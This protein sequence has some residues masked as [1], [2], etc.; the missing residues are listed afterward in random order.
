MLDKN[1]E[2]KGASTD[3]KAS[4][5]TFLSISSFQVLAMFRRGLFYSFLSIY[6]R[7]FLGLSVT[8]TTFFATFPMV[9]NV[10][11]QTFVWGA[12]SDKFQLRRT[13]IILGEISA[14]IT[15]FFVWYVHTLPDNGHIAG[16]VIIVGLSIVEIFW[17]MSNVGWSALLSDLYPEHRRADLQGKLSSVG[18][19]GRIIGV[20]IGG[21]AYDGLSQFY[22]GWG[23]ERGL[24]FFI[25]SGVMIISTIPMFFVPEGGIGKKRVS[26]KGG[27]VSVS[28]KLLVFLL[29]MLF[30]N[31]G[32]NSVA[33]MK[34]Q[35][36]SLD[37]GFDVSSSLLSY[38]ANTG[39]FAIFVVGFL[40][41]QISDRFRDEIMLFI[42]TMTAILYLAGFATA[43]NLPMI[44]A[45][46][47]LYGASNVIIVASSYSF[48][49]RLIPP[50]KRGKQ[51]ALFN[52]TFFLSWGIPGTF[53]VGPIVDQLIRSGTTQVF[54]YRM[55]FVT[56]AILTFI[57]VLILSFV[58]RMNK[59]SQKPPKER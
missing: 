25:A 4:R 44:F 56:A 11:S 49:S 46:N 51:F 23:F 45:S 52:A 54:A 41:R 57:G 40:V 9:L 18:A 36:L 22:E 27:K 33:L 42:G 35:Y 43:E 1:V 28:E 53:I 38:I 20:W 58:I 50:E 21:M 55:S 30:I 12:V 24:L 13:L 26:S 16:Y 17:S 31:F 15:T 3:F 32:I 14:A 39:S 2:N 5:R 19:I 6:L 7:F 37:E 47:F 8:E 34:S 10:L 48:A 29:A 59:S